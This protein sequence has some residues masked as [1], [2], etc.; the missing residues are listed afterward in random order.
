MG[1]KCAEDPFNMGMF[2]DIRHP[3]LWVYFQTLNTHIQAFHTGVAPLNSLEWTTFF[4]CKSPRRD[5]SRVTNSEWITERAPVG[6]FVVVGECRGHRLGGYRG[7]CRIPTA[8]GKQGKWGEKI[9]VREN[10]GNLEILPKTQ[11]TWFAQVVNSLILKIKNISVF[12][13][14][15]S[16]FSGGSG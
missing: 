5:V 13:A 6:G 2:F 9:P 11:G 3:S 1:I 4:H 15:I 14:K 7:I 8:Q 16:I 12:A 10:T